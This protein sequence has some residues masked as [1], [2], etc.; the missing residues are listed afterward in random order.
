VYILYS[1]SIDRFYVGQTE[2]F[3][4]RQT[5]HREHFFK[6]S[7]TVQVD[8]WQVFITI[9]CKTRKQAVNIEAHIKRMKSK[10][11]IQNLM[12]YTEIVEK[13]KRQ[14]SE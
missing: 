3:S 14:Y 12:K 2:N 9:E 7:F 8:D 4:E 13:L 1:P 6:G 11:Y 5:L 10:K